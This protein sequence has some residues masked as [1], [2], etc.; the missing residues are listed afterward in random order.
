MKL[1]RSGGSVVVAPDQTIVRALELAGHR[2]PTS[3]LSGLCGTCKVDYLEGEVDHQDYILS[4]EEKKHCM[5]AC[6]SR[7]TSI[8]LVLDI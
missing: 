4:D 5:T 1:A 8:C 6:V 3:C 2:I 7:A